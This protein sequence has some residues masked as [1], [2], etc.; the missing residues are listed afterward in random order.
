MVLHMNHKLFAITRSLVIVFVLGF[1]PTPFLVNIGYDPLLVSVFSISIML[2]WSD[3]LLTLFATGKGAAEINP[4]MNF[5]NWLAGEK[6]GVWLSRVIG[7]VLPIVGLFEKNLY[8]ILA[9]A[10]FF[11]AV[12]CLNSVTLLSVF[13]EKIDA[14]QTYPTNDQ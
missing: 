10:W 5:L 12:V 4:I 3:G 6:K 7:S 2:L 14:K 9:L 11:A 1:L 13:S 8:F